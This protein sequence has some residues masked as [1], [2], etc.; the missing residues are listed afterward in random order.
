MNF[1]SMA[2]GIA[3]CF[4][5]FFWGNKVYIMIL[6]AHL[7]FFGVNI[8]D[9]CELLIVISRFLPF[10][11]LKNSGLFRFF[12]LIASSLAYNLI[13]VDCFIFI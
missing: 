10:A 12:N 3:I 6:V 5:I 2:L 4:M 8:R 1:F 11:L 9:G 7:A 13:F